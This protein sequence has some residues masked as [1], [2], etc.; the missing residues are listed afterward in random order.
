MNNNFPKPNVFSSKCL[1]FDRCRWN[2]EII[3]VK[4]IET[5]QSHANFITTCPEVEIGLGVPRDPI[6]VIFKD[7]ALSLI[8]F[9]TRKN[10]SKLMNEFSEKFLNS[11]NDIDGFILKDRSPSCGIKDVK[12]YPSLEKSNV[13]YKTNGFFAGEVLKRFPMQAIETETRLSNHS[14]REHFLTKLFTIARFRK[15][16]SKLNMKG[17]IQFHAENK[18]FLMASSQK[19]LKIMGKIVANHD[20]KNIRRVF[21]EYETYI[22][23]A[24]SCKPKYKSNINV[25]MHA[26]GYFSKYLSTKE[27]EFFLNILEEYRREQVPLSVPLKL[28]KA[29]IFRFE[30]G[31]LLQQT[32][33]SPYPLALVDIKDSGKGR[34]H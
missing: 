4:F 21:E 26:F 25:I 9:N 18:L 2:G 17:L 12:V 14:I 34:N 30:I 3:S 20:K 33:F 29:Y 16:K 13:L 27:K 32:F 23:K 28:S 6:R 1:G 5:L 10:V 24:L 22:A 15:L 11:L 7:G 31:Y 8:Q 19:T